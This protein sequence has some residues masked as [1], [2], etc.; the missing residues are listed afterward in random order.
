MQYLN[1]LMPEELEGK[2]YLAWCSVNEDVDSSILS[3]SETG[4]YRSFNS[5]SRKKEFL[6]VRYI[7]KNIASKMGLETS[8]FIINK[9]ENDK[10]EVH[11]QGRQYY[12]SIS[13][14][15]EKVFCAI[16]THFTIGIDI[17]PAGR[18]I[19]VNLRSRILHSDEE[20]ALQGVNTLRIWTVK[21]A[22][23]KL[24]GK[25]LGCSLRDC[26]INNTEMEIYSANI[27][28]EKAKAFSCKYENHWLAIAW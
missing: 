8:N 2:L 15:S 1:S 6:I 4:L 5:S 20:D 13:H 27:G 9:D 3:A 16:S 11:Y 25:E 7:V 14:S 28:D 19:N 24:R 18:Q 22:L 26:V 21:E 12:L 10:P 17:E 23:M